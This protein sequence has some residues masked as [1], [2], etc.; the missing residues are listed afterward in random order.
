[1][2]DVIIIGGGPAGITAAIYCARS[3]LK[4]CIIDKG[5]I[6]GNPL[7]YLEIQNYPGL[8]GTT[9]NLVDKFLEHLDMYDI[10]RFE[11][12]EIENLDLDNKTIKTTDY[13][14]KCKKIIIATGSKP[15]MLG[16]PGEIEHIG[17]G[18]HYC[19]ICDGPLYKDKQVAVIG[20]GNSACEEAL[21][22]SKICDKVYIIEFTDKLNAEQ[23]TIDKIK[24]TKNIMVYTGYAV[25]KIE[26]EEDDGEKYLTLFASPRQEFEKKEGPVEYTVIPRLKLWVNGIFP[27]IGMSPN[28]PTEELP[29]GCLDGSE[30]IRVNENMQT[31]IPDVYAIGDITSKKY[32]QV[33]TAMSDGAIA[34]IHI[35]KN[36]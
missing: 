9:E 10:D 28:L 2:Y 32:R 33:I 30:Y 6:G 18:V 21:G 5:L 23:T 8:P 12:Q 11:F 7:N 27:Y 14:F 35:S 1:M 4:T 3:N 29:V 24:E 34:A 16:V 15:R 13:D 19:A 31:I 17:K 20:G 26:E 36:I 22:L 25:T